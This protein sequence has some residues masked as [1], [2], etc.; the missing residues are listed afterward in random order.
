MR[1]SFA[2]VALHAAFAS[3]LCSPSAFA[4]P[5]ANVEHVE[6]FRGIAQYRLKSNGMTILLAEQNAALALRLSTRAYVLESGR[7][8][9]EGPSETLIR[10]DSVRRLYLG[11]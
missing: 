1:L 3:A 2:L 10:D 4:A 8:S 6:T 9:I 7:I 11:H 5:P